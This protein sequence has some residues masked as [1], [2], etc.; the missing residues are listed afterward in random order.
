MTSKEFTRKCKP[1]NIKYKE[2]FDVVPCPQDYV[3]SQD[4]FFKALLDAIENKKP[5]DDYLVR[6]IKPMD[7]SA[8]I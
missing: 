8:K 3:G 6:S 2:I 5:I 7:E 1:Y 4:D